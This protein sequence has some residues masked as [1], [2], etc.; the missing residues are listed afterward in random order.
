MKPE[1]EEDP[2]PLGGPTWAGAG[3]TLKQIK[4]EL[5][6]A[7]TMIGPKSRMGC[8]PIFSNF[9]NIDLSSKVKDSNVFKPI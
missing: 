8:S 5:E 4:A 9:S 2:P 7:T 1:E 6:R 3:P